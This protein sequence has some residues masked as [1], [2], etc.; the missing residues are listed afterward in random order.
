[1]GE[2]CGV[3]YIEAVSPEEAAAACSELHSS[4]RTKFLVTPSLNGWCAVYPS[5]A[6]QDVGVSL[7]LAQRLRRSTLHVLLHDSD[8][9]A[10]V[11]YRDGE[12]ID[13]FNSAPDYFGEVSAAERER[14]RGDAALLVAT[15]ATGVEASAVAAV[16]AASRR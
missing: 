14:Q 15:L 3:I 10:Y 6:G 2:S 7:Q 11:L 1:M 8:V 9:L 13:E 5:A 16:L 4:A 12:A